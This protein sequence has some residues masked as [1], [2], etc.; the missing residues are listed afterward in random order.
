MGGVTPCIKGGFL[1]IDKNKGPYNP[2]VIKIDV[3]LIS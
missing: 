1:G 3:K 2:H